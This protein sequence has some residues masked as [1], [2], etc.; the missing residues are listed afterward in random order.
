L[1]LA[2]GLSQTNLKMNILLTMSLA[3]AIGIACQFNLI[4]VA[5]TVMVSYLISSPLI[6]IYSYLKVFKNNQKLTSVG[7]SL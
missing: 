6:C 4:T 5:Q 3:M 1:L 2:N 7:E